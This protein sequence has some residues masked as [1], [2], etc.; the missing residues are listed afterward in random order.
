MSV[1]NIEPQYLKPTN[2]NVFFKYDFLNFVKDS[3]NIDIG[4]YY[5]FLNGM[6]IFKLKNIYNYLYLRT[7]KI[8]QKIGNTDILKKCNG[9]LSHEEMNQMLTNFINKDKVKSIIIMNGIQ[10]Y[11]TPLLDS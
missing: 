6:E 3:Y 7:Y 5:N 4:K 9:N 10:L 2:K 11:F 8:N 1:L